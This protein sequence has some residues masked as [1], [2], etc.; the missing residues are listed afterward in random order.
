M[1]G[2]A[3]PDGEFLYV[4]IGH[5]GATGDG[6]AI[7]GS[8]FWQSCEKDTFKFSD[9]YFWIGDNAYGLMPWMITPYA[10]TK[11][12]SK[13]GVFNLQ[14][15]RARQVIE[16]A[17]GMTIER[18]RILASPL[19]YTESQSVKIVKLC[20]VLNNMTLKDNLSRK[21]VMRRQDDINH[22]FIVKER[23][24]P[25]ILLHENDYREPDVLF[26]AAELAENREKDLR[27]NA[28]LKRSII[29]ET[30]KARGVKREQTRGRKRGAAYQQA[31]VNNTE[32]KKKRART[33]DDNNA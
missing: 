7:R 15:A 26:T 17:L 29:A 18:F 19:A 31:V 24:V 28:V 27:R 25:R 9:G 1:Q 10:D 13:E 33:A 22:P 2:V 21:I 16:R 11:L 5:A 20:C 3:G 8:K 6:C 32:S 30:L 23:L 12:N 4:N 14:L